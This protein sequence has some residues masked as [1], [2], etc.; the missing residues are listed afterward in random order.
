MNENVLNEI[1]NTL[2]DIKNDLPAETSLY[3]VE[4]KLDKL[5]ELMENQND[6]TEQLLNKME[7]VYQEMPG[8]NNVSTYK[9]EDLRKSGIN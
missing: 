1:N 2:N 7:N 4:K 6:L 9:I 3:D 8:E 5:I